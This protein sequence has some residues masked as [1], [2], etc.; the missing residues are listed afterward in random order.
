MST[1]VEIV[2][3]LGLW[4]AVVGKAWRDWERLHRYDR[5]RRPLTPCERTK[6]IKI[7]HQT[8]DSNTEELHPR[9]WLMGQECRMICEMV[10]RDHGRLR[11]VVTTQAI[12]WQERLEAA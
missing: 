3:M 4:H 5:T 8:A 12:R 9:D 1:E 7:L 6:R 2:C 11:Q 10:G